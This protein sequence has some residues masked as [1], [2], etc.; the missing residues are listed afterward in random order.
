MDIYANPTQNA[1]E[2]KRSVMQLSRQGN[3]PGQPFSNSFDLS[4]FW[5]DTKNTA[6]KVIGYVTNNPVAVASAQAAD[7]VNAAIAEAKANGSIPPD[8][9]SV[10]ATDIAPRT[11]QVSI[12]LF[13]GWLKWVILLIVAYLFIKI[14]L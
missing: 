10:S 4:S 11:G 7:D 14:I 9:Q 13:D 6:T 12:S 3:L 5:T 1:Y 2:Y 8:T